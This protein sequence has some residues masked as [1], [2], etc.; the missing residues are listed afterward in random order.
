MG[1]KQT[2]FDAPAVAKEWAIAA[3]S[4]SHALQALERELPS[5]R[6]RMDH[7]CV[8]CQSFYDEAVSTFPEDRGK[9]FAAIS[10]RRTSGQKRLA[11]QLEQ[12]LAMEDVYMSMARACDAVLLHRGDTPAEALLQLR[13]SLP[14][15]SCPPLL[16]YLHFPDISEVTSTLMM[17]KM[18][19][20]VGSITVSGQGAEYCIIGSNPS[21]REYNTFTVEVESAT[22]LTVDDIVLSLTAPAGDRGSDVDTPIS[23]TFS[24]TELPFSRSRIRFSVSYTVLTHISRRYVRRL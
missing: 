3:E 11:A 20:D 22:L 7:I 10:R 17:S 12:V 18:L 15:P 19:M 5:L 8:G 14:E 21:A 9:A 4:C 6:E 16:S 2:R 24:V 13:S 23:A 1:A